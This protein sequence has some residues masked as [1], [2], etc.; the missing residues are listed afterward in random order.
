MRWKEKRTKE[1][2]R[3]KERKWRNKRKYEC[4]IKREENEGNERER[5]KILNR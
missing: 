4:D 3:G 5:S 2:K 1:R